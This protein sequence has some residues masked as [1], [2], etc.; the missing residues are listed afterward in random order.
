MRL[1]RPDSPSISTIIVNYNG[2]QYLDDCLSSLARQ[3]CQDFETILVDNGSSDGSVH[4]IQENYPEVRLIKNETNRGFCGGNNDGISAARGDFVFLL[5]NDTVIDPECMTILSEGL[6][7]LPSDCLGVFPKVLFHGAPSFINAAGC[8]WNYSSFWRDIRVGLLDVDQYQDPEPVFGSIFAAVLLK[9]EPFEQINLFDEDFF[10]YGEDFD[11]CY[12]AHV[13]GYSFYMIPKAVIYHKY[14]GSSRE[15]R[16][17]LWA[18]Y[19]FLRNYYFMLFKNLSGKMLW[20]RR[21]S[22]VHFFLANLYW[23][24]QQRDL[25]RV[26]LAVKVLNSLVRHAPALIRKRRW[27]QTRRKQPDSA[28]WDFSEREN[29]NIF[30]YCGWP[31]L[32]LLN[33]KTALEKGCRYK[34]GAG[35][36]YLAGP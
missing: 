5:N 14:R 11:V 3:T 35:K 8:V 21:K 16:D 32:S 27:I 13:L 23:A 28:F 30:H 31:V 2:C 34:I 24:L 33:L 36:E 26:R 19:Y 25:K 22:V 29:H 9:K 6:K 12:R 7:E 17:P 10:T 1:A 18:Y 20:R 4:F 15:D